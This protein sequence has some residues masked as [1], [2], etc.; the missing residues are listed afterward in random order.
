MVGSDLVARVRS[1]RTD[2]KRGNRRIERRL[3]QL[4]DD[5]HEPDLETSI[6]R[7]LIMLRAGA[8]HKRQEIPGPADV[9]TDGD[10]VTVNPN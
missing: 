8:E 10:C 5:D 7:V 4:E 9:T 6:T 3:E 1:R 2:Q